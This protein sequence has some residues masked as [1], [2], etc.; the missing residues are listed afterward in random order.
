[1]SF[2]CNPQGGSSR[3]WHQRARR[4][5]IGGKRSEGRCRSS[6]CPHPSEAYLSGEPMREVG[7]VGL[8][9]ALWRRRTAWRRKVLRSRRNA[10]VSSPTG[11]AEEEK[12]SV[13]LNGALTFILHTTPGSFYWAGEIKKTPNNLSNLGQGNQRHGNN[14]HPTIAD[15]FPQWCWLFGYFKRK[16]VQTPYESQI[17]CWP[18][19]KSKWC[20]DWLRSGLWRPS[21]L[22]GY[23]LLLKLEA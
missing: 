20:T 11:A 1:M 15:F 10:T 12:C 13:R 19:M 4:S 7:G 22:T 14:P 2:Q 18:I 5:A 6:I 17:R 9:P 8:L 16:H 3:H 23:R 21:P